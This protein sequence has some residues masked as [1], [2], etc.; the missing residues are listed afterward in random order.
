MRAPQVAWRRPGG[1]RRR[2]SSS[3]LTHRRNDESI[4]AGGRAVRPALGDLLVLGPEADAFRPMLV[5]VAEARALPAAEG[6]VG[7]RHRDR[8]VDTDHADIDPGGELARGV[9]VA[10]E[11]GNAIAIFMLARQP[12]RLLE[13]G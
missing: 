9:A 6:V 11:D 2:G 5:D 4:L 3:L 12:H 8:H 13:I 10:G 1:E 7:D